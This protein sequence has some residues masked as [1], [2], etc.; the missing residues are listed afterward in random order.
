[1]HTSIYPR[2]K[3]QQPQQVSAGHDSVQKKTPVLQSK[4]SGLPAS[5]RSGLEQM[6]TGVQPHVSG[7][8]VVQ[9]QIDW[10]EA[11]RQYNR[12]MADPLI[13]FT[14]FG[15]TPV[16]LNNIEIPGHGDVSKAITGPAFLIEKT[17]DNNIK[18]SVHTE[19]INR[20]GYR[21]G[22]PS[23]PPWQR[24]TSIGNANVR[25]QS[26]GFS[27][28]DSMIP[29]SDEKDEEGKYKPNNGVQ[30]LV[31]AHGMPNDAVFAKLVEHHENIHLNDLTK[32]LRNTLS[33][34]DKRISRFKEK[35]MSVTAGNVQE[36]Q[37]KF[38]KMIG[39]TPAAKGE[40]FKR[41]LI[42]HSN[43]YHHSKEGS[44][45]QIETTSF[46]NGVLRVY[47][48]HPLS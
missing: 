23:A 38:Y 11:G 21:M 12:N 46:A 28:S 48:K 30:I 33:P 22:L 5:L 32:I 44:S 37:E 8:G 19:A 16:I 13:Q 14:D 6:H 42:E 36:A 35:D 20:V 47:W 26:Q 24:I 27:I 25:L 10:V 2:T 40:E 9:R 1:M 3:V 41:E 31:D 17:E 4:S 18:L 15:I 45:P 29:R 7:K 43:F 39:G 34:W